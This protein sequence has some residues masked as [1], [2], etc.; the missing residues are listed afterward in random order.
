PDRASTAASV[1]A[2]LIYARRIPRTLTPEALASEDELRACI[3]R[4]LQEL[5]TLQSAALVL[6]ERVGLELEEIAELLGVSLCN[7]R[8]LLHR[9]RSRVFAAIDRHQACGLD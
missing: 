7:A 9:A 1:D 3:E 2:W 4:T 6:R 8:V 5:S